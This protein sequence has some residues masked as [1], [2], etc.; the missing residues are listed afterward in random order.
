MSNERPLWR[1][2]VEMPDLPDREEAAV[3]VDRPSHDRADV[4][5]PARVDLVL[6]QAR[7]RRLDRRLTLGV[8][9]H[10]GAAPEQRVV[11]ESGLLQSG[12]ELGPDRCM[13]PF[14]L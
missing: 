3:L 9:D 7:E 8:C 6:V 10:L 13:P 11:R 5:T 4:G 2:S 1:T 14:I 12:H